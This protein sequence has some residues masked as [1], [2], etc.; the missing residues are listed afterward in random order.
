MPSWKKTNI[1]M[2]LSF[3]RGY[4]RSGDIIFSSSTCSVNSLLCFTGFTW[5]M[6]MSHLAYSFGK[7]VWCFCP[8]I[9]QAIN[10]HDLGTPVFSPALLT[11]LRPA[12]KLYY[13]K[14]I[15][16]FIIHWTG[17]KTGA[18][19]SR[20]NLVVCPIQV[21]HHTAEIRVWHSGAAD[22]YT[23]WWEIYCKSH[24]SLQEKHGNLT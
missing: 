1:R 4:C 3:S 8:C 15:R 21:P 11:Q 23:S 19:R 7:E 13:W 14:S 16:S 9:S 22:G 5:V 10:A 12:V 17:C 6:R 24:S 18:P 20:D 2:P